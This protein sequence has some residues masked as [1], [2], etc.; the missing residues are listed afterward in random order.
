MRPWW[1]MAACVLLVGCSSGPASR[2]KPVHAT[3]VPASA[4]AADELHRSAAVLRSRLALAHVEGAT[5][6][7]T[8]YGSLLVSVPAGSRAKLRGLGARDL[9][10][11]RPV[12]SQ[13]I[14]TGGPCQPGPVPQPTGAVRGCSPDGTSAYL[15]GRLVLDSSGVSSARAAR[16]PVS[17]T[18]K[19]RLTC[20][21]AAAQS[22]AA[23]TAGASGSRLAITV[24]GT[25]VAS[26]VVAGAIT[27]RDVEITAAYETGEARNL[28]TVLTRKAL[29]VAFHRTSG[30]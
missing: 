19:V 21:A 12:L 2:P 20:T 5:V 13:S 25:V 28:V 15:L 9:V 8:T 17:R 23:A 26:P 14:V 6:E 1:A 24:D 29:P 18:W 4:L 3:F 7:V 11:L 30:A 10:E 27:G 16:D 22:L